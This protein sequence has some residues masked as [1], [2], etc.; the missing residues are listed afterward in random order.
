MFESFFVDYVNGWWGLLIEPDQ[1]L[2]GQGWLVGF[3]DLFVF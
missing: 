1:L 3:G 2:R